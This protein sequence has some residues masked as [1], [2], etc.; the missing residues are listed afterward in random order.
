[1]SSNLFAVAVALACLIAVG[2]SDE[3]EKVPSAASER[4]AAATEIWRQASLARE[5]GDFDFGDSNEEAYYRWS[6]RLADAAIAAGT[7]ARATAYAEHVARMAERA[8][9]S[10]VLM[11]MGR[12]SILQGAIARYYAADARVLLEEAKDK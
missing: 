1:M 5:R 2:L 9:A 12:S 11:T 7:Q 4:L 6:L 3:Q 10:E 8:K